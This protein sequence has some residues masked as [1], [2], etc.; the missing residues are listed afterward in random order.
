MPVYEYRCSSC[1]HQ[2]ELRQKFSDQPASQ[3]PE[4]GG[5]VQKMISSTAFSLKG[6][7]WFNQ[8][9]CSKTQSP[10]PASCPGGGCCAA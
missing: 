3:C 5:T 2:F 9:Y 8:G 1:D 10:K 7:G 6:D 4:C